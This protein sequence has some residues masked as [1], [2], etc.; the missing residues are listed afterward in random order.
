MAAVLA[1]VGLLL[2]STVAP[3]S[4]AA[5]TG[6]QWAEVALSVAKG[7]PG[8]IKDIKALQAL[9][10]SPEFKAWAAANGDYVIRVYPGNVN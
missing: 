5:I 8:A 1:L 6:L 9:L 3:A 4:L 10:N 7:A 2:G